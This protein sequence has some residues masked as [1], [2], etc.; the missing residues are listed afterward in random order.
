M[1]FSLRYILLLLFLL[2]IAASILLN[3]LSYIGNDSPEWRNQIL[4]Y[5]TEEDIRA[6]EDYDRSGFEIGII[7]SIINF[8]FL[9]LFAFS[10]LS[11]KMES[12]CAKISRRHLAV[13]IPIF[14]FLYFLLK[15]AITLPFNFYFDYIIEHEHG[16]SKMTI[17]DWLFFTFKAKLVTIAIT[18]PVATSALLTIKIFPKRW[19]PILSVSALLFGLMA[20]VIFPEIITPIFYEVN[21]IPDGPLKNKIIALCADAKIEIQSISIINE[22]RYSGHTNAYF[23]GWGN[24][25]KIS[26]YDTLIKTNSDAELMSILGHEIG[27]WK[28]GHVLIQ[29]FLSTAVFFFFCLLIKR[30]SDLAIKSGQFH[31]SEIY[32]PA[33]IPFILLIFGLFN[34]ALS[35][36]DNGLSRKFES[37]ADLFSLE[38]TKNPKAAMTAEIRLARDNKSRLNPH[39]I[40]VKF[41]YSHPVTIDRIKMAEEFRLPMK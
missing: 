32:S 18:L 5:F 37:D 9:G 11:G 24:Q 40:A 19:I 15:L 38:L 1:K 36:L 33:A 7:S 12:F 30:L 8:V 28:K 2:E 25:K 3:Y 34:F 16:F 17:A 10:S 21:P 39:P 20:S 4:K 23:T 41:Y 14:I 26:L 31:F 27:H 22:S 35:P 13:T 29:L 6:G